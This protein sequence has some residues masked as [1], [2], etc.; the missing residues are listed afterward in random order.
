MVSSSYIDQTHNRSGK[1]SLSSLLTL[2]TGVYVGYVAYTSTAVPSLS[3]QKAQIKAYESFTSSSS[4]TSSASQHPLNKITD[5]TNSNVRRNLVSYHDTDHTTEAA[6]QRFVENQKL[7]AS[8]SIP[9]ATTPTVMKTPRLPDSE[10]KKILVTGGA[11]FVGSHLVDKLMMKGHEVIVLDNFFTGQKKNVE[12]WLHHPNFR[13]VFVYVLKLEEKMSL[14]FF[15]YLLLQ[16]GTLFFT[17]TVLKK[18]EQA[19]RFFFS[20][21]SSHLVSLFMMSQSQSCSKLTKS[22]TSPVQP[23]HLTINTTQSK[24]SKHLLWV[25]STCLVLP[26]ESRHVCS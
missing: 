24:P 16:I 22:T 23:L 4:S 1:F 26:N 13:Y 14:V 25:P 10:R 21:P 11:G 15:C 12:H 8:Q 6:Q 19:H 18:V 17:Y 3:S 7:L 20:N 2:I 5:K 9:T